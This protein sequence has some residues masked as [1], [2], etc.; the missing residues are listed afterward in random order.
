MVLVEDAAESISSSDG[1]VIPAAW[2][3]DWLGKWAKGSCS[4]QGAVCPVVVV[5]RFE[6]PQGSQEVGLVQ[7]EGAVEQLGWAG[8]DPAFYDRVH[9]WDADPGPIVVM[10]LSARTASKAAV[11]LLSRSR[12]RYLTVALASCRP[13]IRL[14]AL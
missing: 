8:A 14:L 13:M 6:F 3:A 12:I 5:E 9:P 10:A 7:D 11:Y 4:V 1:E 2:F